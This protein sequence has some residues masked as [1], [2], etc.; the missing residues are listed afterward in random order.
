VPSGGH[1]CC[2]HLSYGHLSCG[3]GGI[4]AGR[5]SRLRSAACLGLLLSAVL[6]VTGCAKTCPAVA[7]LNF[8]TVTVDGDTRN[9]AW[10]QL[11]T[12]D[13]CSRATARLTP[14]PV[15]PT[16]TPTPTP[17]GANGLG[18][19]RGLG[20]VERHIPV[21]RTGADAWRFGFLVDLPGAVTLRA[22]D[23]AGKILA[24]KRLSL[25]WQQ[26]GRATECGAPAMAAPVTLTVN[27]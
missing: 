15:L 8:V 3:H 7:W 16:A 4:Y 1:L 22:F 21:E 23:S 12:P 18:F 6:Q 26:T 17:T 19:P 10:V 11:C 27:A 13:A 20:P 24:E 9:V 25:V 14:Q 5:M 2:G